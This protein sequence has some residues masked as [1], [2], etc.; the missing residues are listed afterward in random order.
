[1][2]WLEV[3]NVCRA[4]GALAE[5]RAQHIVG[6]QGERRR[7]TRRIVTLE[8]P[9]IVPAAPVQRFGGHPI[10]DQRGEVYV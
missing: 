8:T 4:L 9:H 10:G 6:V 5:L 3:V 2:K 7:A 1:M